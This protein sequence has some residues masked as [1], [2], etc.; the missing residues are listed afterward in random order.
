MIWVG[1]FLCLCIRRVYTNKA[2]VCVEGQAISFATILAEQLWCHFCTSPLKPT[3]V[4]LFHYSKSK[5][6]V[7]GCFVASAM[8]QDRSACILLYA[9]SEGTTVLG[10]DTI[11]ALQ[12]K[13]DGI[14]IQSLTP[15]TPALPSELRSEYEHLLDKQLGFA[16]GFKHK[17]RVREPVLPA[18][19][20]GCPLLFSWTADIIEH[21]AVGFSN[22]GGSEKGWINTNVRW[23][24]RTQ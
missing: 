12:M 11:V 4:Q 13:A 9:A 1:A 5:I 20:E 15:S 2:S 24:A 7:E 8:F 14:S 21:L 16:N 17:F 23:S 19:S 6:G 18:S 22:S 10:L 3:S